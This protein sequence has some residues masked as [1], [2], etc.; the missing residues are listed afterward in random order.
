[1]RAVAEYK[2]FLLLL[3][4]LVALAWLTLWL[5]GH[6]PYG[7]YLAHHEMPLA[8][9][10]NGPM[11]LI[12][13]LGWLLMII[14]MMLPTSVPLLAVF[15]RMTRQ[16]ADR[17]PLI[18]LVTTGY[19]NIWAL[20]GVVALLGDGLLH[21]AVE[22][23]VWLE[24]NAWLTGTGIL[25]MAGLYQFTP[26]KFYCLEKCR[27]PLH[28]I[29]THWQGR[30]DHVQAFRLGLRHGLF[31]VG[32]CWSL[33]LLMFAVGVGNLGWMLVLGATMALEKNLPWGR[34]FSTLV[35][36][37]LVCWGGMEAMLAVL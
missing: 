13:M 21:E 32:C 1:M 7:R 27:S 18:L 4:G 8:D 23:S 24:A 16:R 11:L 17:T 19:L 9:V 6:S 33:M 29:V 34:W 15:R 22:Q 37:L 28:F 12:I 10:E 30:R 25:V 2:G 14:A 35:G 36:A 26:L 31:C 5:G 20:F 3:S